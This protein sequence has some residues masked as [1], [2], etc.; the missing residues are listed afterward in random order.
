M[1]LLLG[2][3]G[4]L[5]IAGGSLYI[6]VRAFTTS[7]LW[8]VGCLLISPVM[9][10]F[11]MLHWDGAKAGVLAAVAGTVVLFLAGLLA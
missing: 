8:G 4:L 11:A 1:S 6:L 3:A 7:V 2:A 5:L 10:V 9:I